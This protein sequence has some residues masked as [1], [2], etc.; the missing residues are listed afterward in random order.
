MEGDEAH[1]TAFLLGAPS[2]QAAGC[3]MQRI[4]KLPPAWVVLCNFALDDGPG[5]L[6]RG[7]C[8]PGGY[9]CH[10][11]APSR[12]ASP[13]IAEACRLEHLQ[14]NFTPKIQTV[15]SVGL[16]LWCLKRYSVTYFDG[17]TTDEK[18]AHDLLG[19]RCLGPGEQN[20]ATWPIPK[21][22][23]LPEA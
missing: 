14:G 13:P 10:P 8:Q 7:L 6:V 16:L 15:N 23:T 9:G 2:L 4:L 20:H 22:T 19:S 5:L 18:S 3:S 1:Y 11:F 17:C 21:E 12:P